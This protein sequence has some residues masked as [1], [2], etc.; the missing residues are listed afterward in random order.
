MIGYTTPGVNDL[1]RARGFYDAVLK[2]LGGRR[3]LAYER[4]QH[5]TLVL[6]VELVSVIKP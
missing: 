1:E 6:E 2:P 4:S 3:T 5:A